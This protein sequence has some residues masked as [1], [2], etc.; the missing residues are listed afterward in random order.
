MQKPV[1][2]NSFAKSSKKSDSNKSIHHHDSSQGLLSPKKN[3]RVSFTTSSEFADGSSS[4]VFLSSSSSSISGT[5]DNQEK[6]SLPPS[7]PHVGGETESANLPEQ[8]KEQNVAKKTVSEESIAVERFSIELQNF[9]KNFFNGGDKKEL[10]KFRLEDVRD[11]A[12]VCLET[13]FNDTIQSQRDYID[14]RKRALEKQY[15]KQLVGEIPIVSTRNCCICKKSEVFESLFLP[16]ECTHSICYRCVIPILSFQIQSFI[17]T[18]ESEK[19]KQ[20]TPQYI[21]PISTCKK[22]I[23]FPMGS[24]K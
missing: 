7:G 5:E 19:T 23:A 24:S 22:N 16:K 11:K 8:K 14:K 12:L 18:N 10:L 6:K 21:C 9:Y 2:K 15:E 1:S 20:K 17:S 3:N 13:L 4:S